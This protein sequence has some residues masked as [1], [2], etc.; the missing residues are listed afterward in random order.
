MCAQPNSSIN[1]PINDFMAPNEDN[2]WDIE[3]HYELHSVFYVIQF[4][5]IIIMYYYM[6]I[7]IFGL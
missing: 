5:A 7:D 6:F 1:I 3:S 4:I 2:Q